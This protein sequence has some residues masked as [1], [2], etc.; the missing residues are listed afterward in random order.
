M[1]VI[2][3]LL[4][5]LHDLAEAVHARLEVG[6]GLG[7]DAGTAGLV[8]LEPLREPALAVPDRLTGL[9]DAGGVHLDLDLGFYLGV[10]LRH[11]SGAVE[12]S[13]SE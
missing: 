6:C 8:A 10:D 2:D 4:L 13:R 9:G 3:L 7:D 11:D 1:V 12:G 5:A